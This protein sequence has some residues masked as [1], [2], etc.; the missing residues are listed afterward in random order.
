MRNLIPA[1]EARGRGS[2]EALIG[3]NGEINASSRT[4]LMQK[5]VEI[6]GM[7]QEGE[8]ATDAQLNAAETAAAR[9]ETINE[10]FHE[11]TRWA[12]LGAAIALDIN[13]R[14]ERE[15]FM[16]TILA[17]ADL[18]ENSGLP[19]IRVREK[20][21]MAVIS[22]GPVQVY[23]RYIRDKYI[24]AEEFYIS[25][26]PRVEEIELRQGS[27]DIL[28]EKYFEGLE[29]ILVKEDQTVVKM[30]RDTDG[31]Y[32]P[33]TY[34]SG[35]F[36]PSLLNTAKQN[37]ERWRLP[38]SGIILAYD[39]I[40]DLVAGSDYSTWFDPISKWEIVQTGRIGRLLGMEILTDGY[41]EPTLKVLDPG[42]ALIL[43][44]P[45][46]LGGYTDRGPVQSR[47]VDEFDKLIPA[48]GWNMM[49][50]LSMVVASA[51]GVSRI[52]RQ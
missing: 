17:R 4:D 32:N 18:Q 25:S 27:G 45:E 22:R 13:S 36:T 43:T 19:R 24:T 28:E 42:E 16:R 1:T 34:F 40:N 44:T 50:I 47:P 9:R 46:Y 6:A 49:E 35:N 23:P 48:R 2:R 3:R 14:L 20:N 21:V 5:L 51:K 30:L 26:L 29:A 8:I 10:A 39:L 37:I 12:E 15:G 31:L 7:I 41:R 33:V 52:K 11:P 38:V